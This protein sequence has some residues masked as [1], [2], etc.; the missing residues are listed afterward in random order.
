MDDTI[1]QKRPKSPVSTIET[2]S[3]EHSPRPVLSPLIDPRKMSPTLTPQQRFQKKKNKANE[4][5][6]IENIL[7]PVLIHK[8][9]RQVIAKI[10][11]KRKKEKAEEAKR[12]TA[13]EARIK[14]EKEDEKRKKEEAEFNLQQEILNLEKMEQNKE[15]KLYLSPSNS[16]FINSYLKQG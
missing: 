4:K 7:N 2:P 8:T 15:A 5:K 12:L 3:Q 16:G 10:K 9:H 6:R 1:G 14:T 11:E 13:E